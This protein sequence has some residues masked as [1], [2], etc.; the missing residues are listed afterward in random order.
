MP[1]AAKWDH[2]GLRW[3]MYLQQ[4]LT[5]GFNLTKSWYAKVRKH[6]WRGE[7]K[8]CQKIIRETIKGKRDL[9]RMNQILIWHHIQLLLI[10]YNE[11]PMCIFFWPFSCSSL[12]SYITC[13]VLSTG[14]KYECLKWG[15]TLCYTWSALIIWYTS[16]SKYCKSF[17]VAF[18][19][20]RSE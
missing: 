4:W 8:S 13:H 14:S 15:I 1:P 18:F 5:N 17:N 7:W 19:E 16:K 9:C 11:N 6:T 10:C 12:G 3:C 2:C 20:V